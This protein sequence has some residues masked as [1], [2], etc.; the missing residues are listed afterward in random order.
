MHMKKVLL[1]LISEFKFLEL[2]MKLRVCVFVC[3][4][5]YVP[6]IVLPCWNNRYPYNHKQC[7]YISEEEEKNTKENNAI[8][9][10][11]AYQ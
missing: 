3:M 8:H 6:F 10:S 5:R 11:I 1:I 9:L 7:T 2:N 4:E